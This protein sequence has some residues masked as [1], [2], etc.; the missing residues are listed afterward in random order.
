MMRVWRAFE[1]GKGC[2]C[3]TSLR[4]SGKGTVVP[5]SCFLKLKVMY[6]WARWKEVNEELQ[7]ESM[8]QV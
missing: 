1:M 6:L 2:S 8:E 3:G 5:T 7:L 4:S